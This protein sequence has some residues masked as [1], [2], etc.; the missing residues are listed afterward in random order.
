MHY[1]INVWAMCP[2]GRYLQGIYKS[3][4][5]GLSNI[6]E[7]K[8]CR[9]QGHPDNWGECYDDSVIARFRQECC[10]QCREGYYVAII[11]KGSCDLIN[12]INN[13]KHC[14]MQ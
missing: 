9:P 5:R 6:K 13:Y 2:E 12:C 1:S 8:C 10:I 3:W 14:R 4:P 7:G 11:Q